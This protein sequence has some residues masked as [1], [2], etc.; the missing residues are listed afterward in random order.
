MKKRFIKFYI[1]YT[2]KIPILFFSVILFGVMTIVSLS[3]L[4]KTS[5][6]ISSDCVINNCSII[7]DGKIESH[8]G[9]IYVYSDRNEQ[10]Y[11]VEVYET[12]YE[13]NKTIFL[14]KGNHEFISDM[15]KKEIKVDIPIRE[16]TILERVFLKGGKING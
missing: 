7:V 11:S 12:N 10:I 9:F 4:T 13:N 16:I 1:K 14:V 8:T 3:L 5:V 6:I 2:T 15:N